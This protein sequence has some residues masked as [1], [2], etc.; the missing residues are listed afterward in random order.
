MRTT[1]KSPKTASRRS[2]RTSIAWVCDPSLVTASLTILLLAAQRDTRVY[3]GIE[4]V[5]QH[6]YQHHRQGDYQHRPLHGG[7]VTLENRL[8]HQAP[9]PRQLEDLL[10][11]HQPT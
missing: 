2:R 11:H 1:M 5:H 10:R 6:V 7:V 8:D 3:E 4:Q 9:Q